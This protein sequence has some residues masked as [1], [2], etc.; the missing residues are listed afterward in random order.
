[1]LLYD[2][3]K[4]KGAGIGEALYIQVPLFAD[5]INLVQSDIQLRIKAYNYCKTF[6]TPPYPSLQDTPLT[7]IDDFTIIHAELQAA[8]SANK[9]GN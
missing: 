3:A 9:K 5:A 8:S 1:M 2:E 4:E 7:Y 6:S